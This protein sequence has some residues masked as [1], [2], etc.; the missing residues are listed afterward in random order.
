MG[1]LW[2]MVNADLELMKNNIFVKVVIN[3]FLLFVQKLVGCKEMGDEVLKAVE[4]QLPAA[5]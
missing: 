3:G 2:S 5:L 4:S 1:S